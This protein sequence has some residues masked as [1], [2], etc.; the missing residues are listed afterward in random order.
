[1]RLADRTGR[2]KEGGFVFPEK[3]H[4]ATYLARMNC[5]RRVSIR[6]RVRERVDRAPRRGRFRELVEL[7]TPER[8]ERVTEE[9]RGVLAE[10]GEVGEMTLSPGSRFPQASTAEISRRCRIRDGI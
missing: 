6:R 9:L 10:T 1:M 7:E 8:C 5:G 2:F 4:V 3:K